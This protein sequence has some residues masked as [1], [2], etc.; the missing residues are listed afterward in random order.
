[1]VSP[2]RHSRLLHRAE[3]FHMHVQP[4]LQA[5]PSKGRLLQRNPVE[6]TR[7]LHPGQAEVPLRADE[8]EKRQRK[9]RGKAC[10]FY[11]KSLDMR[12][13]FW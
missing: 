2:A 1:M 5:F 9:R 8:C 12:V 10:M 7:T 4:K 13:F 6:C 11:A 3:A